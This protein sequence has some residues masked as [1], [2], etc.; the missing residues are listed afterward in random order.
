MLDNY[1]LVFGV[2]L[3]VC[4][5]TLCYFITGYLHT[6]YGCKQVRVLFNIFNSVML[7]NIFAHFGKSAVKT[8]F[9]EK[10]LLVFA[11]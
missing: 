2:C 9:I 5:C 1:A 10:K 7:L 6:A 4:L 11:A 3:L 8:R